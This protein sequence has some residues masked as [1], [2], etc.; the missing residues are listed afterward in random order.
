MRS[1]SVA[2]R[3]NAPAW[4]LG[5]SV[6]RRAGHT[7]QLERLTVDSTKISE[8]VPSFSPRR[9]LENLPAA[10]RG[11]VANWFH[12]SVREGAHE[13]MRVLQA[14]RQVCLRRLHWGNE[15]DADAVLKALERDR[16]G[17]LAYARSIIAYEALPHPERQRVKAVRTLQYVRQLMATK[18]VTEPQRAYLHAL[19]YQGPAPTD[20]AAAS[21]LID[22]LRQRRGRA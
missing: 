1:R 15:T 22:E 14:V 10:R 11:V 18:P 13:P 19:G 20:R 16:E 2:R 6:N 8:V 21:A 4:R 3:S 12:H 7:A 9:W 17:A 5:R